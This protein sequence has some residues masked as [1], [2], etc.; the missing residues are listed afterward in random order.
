MASTTRSRSDGT[1][2][3][4][5][6]GWQ[7]SLFTGYDPLTGKRV[8]LTQTV[9]TEAEARKALTRFRSQ[10]DEQRAPR[11]RVDLS[12]VLAEWLAVQELEASTRSAYE[13]NIR[14]HIG[15]ALGSLPIAKITPQ[16][17]ERFYAELRRCR[18]R[19]MPSTA[20]GLLTAALRTRC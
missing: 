13:T 9:A 14:T 17:L 20:S 12:Y 4:R 11:S 6:D 19:C 7:A 18:A 15:P 3:R 10:R 5:A 8:Y 1:I 16:V 2:R